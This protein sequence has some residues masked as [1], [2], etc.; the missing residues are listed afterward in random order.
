MKIIFW[1]VLL[2][3][4]STI[5]NREVVS[6]KL[7]FVGRAKIAM[8]IPQYQLSKE[9]KEKVIVWRTGGVGSYLCTGLGSNRGCIGQ[10]QI[11]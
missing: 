4:I 3:G 10:K 5:V 6:E 2:K 8:K 7:W 1:F 9:Y 11:T